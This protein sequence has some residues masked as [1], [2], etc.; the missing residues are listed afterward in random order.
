VER[1]SGGIDGVLVSLPDKT[2]YFQPTGGQQRQKLIAVHTLR[3]RPT[4]TEVPISRSSCSTPGTVAAVAVGT[5]DFFAALFVRAFAAALVIR[6]HYLAIT[7][8][9]QGGVADYGRSALMASDLGRRG[10][11]RRVGLEGDT[12]VRKAAYGYAANTEEVPIL[13]R[14]LVCPETQSGMTRRCRDNVH[15]SPDARGGL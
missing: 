6:L 10:R 5:A 3:N 12:T 7:L 14:A 2:T 11:R 15:L 9:H 4:W 1:E 8:G 13:V